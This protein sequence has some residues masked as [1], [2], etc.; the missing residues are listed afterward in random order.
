MNENNRK[1]I[2]FFSNDFKTDLWEAELNKYNYEVVHRE[3]R[4]LSHIK[5]LLSRNFKNEEI[6]AFIFRYLMYEW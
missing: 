2:L 5:I 1:R 3:R 6:H 4:F